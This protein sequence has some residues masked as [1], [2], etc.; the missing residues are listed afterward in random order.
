MEHSATQPDSELRPGD[1]ETLTIGNLGDLYR[2][3]R[4]PDA[5]K[6]LTT[7]LLRPFARRFG[8]E[9]LQTDRRVAEIGLQGAM[10]ETLVRFE[11]ELQPYSAETI[12]TTGPLLIT[13]NHP[14]LSDAPALLASLSRPDLKILGA[15]RD[16]WAALPAL[17]ARLA[18]I[19]PARPQ[20]SVAAVLTHLR[21]GGALLTFPA[22]RMHQTRPGARR[23][24]GRDVT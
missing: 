9:L 6:P 19:D 3:F 17:R 21:S 2:A 18:V 24:R 16:L 4:V 1:L 11:V 13:A 22:G 20:R 5:L 8:L 23:S 12:P 7:P 15:E 14:G 10:A